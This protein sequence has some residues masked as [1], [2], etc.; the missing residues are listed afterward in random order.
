MDWHAER[1]RRRHWRRAED[2][3]RR[4]WMCL[5]PKGLTR[6]YAITLIRR[7]LDDEDLGGWGYPGGVS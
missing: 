7:E 1:G 6:C 3:G 2:G 5:L 4:P